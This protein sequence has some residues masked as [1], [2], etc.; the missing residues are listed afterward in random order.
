MSLHLAALFAMSALLTSVLVPLVI[1]I[2]RRT[3]FLDLPG[4]RKIHAAAVPYGGGLA[5]AAGFFLSAGA[6]VA[7]TG[8]G[9]KFP[10]LFAMSG[11]GLVI[12]LLGLID[13]K[14]KL[15]PST[16][17]AV[18]AVV[19][20][21]FVL[22]GERL[23]LFWEG[24]LAGDA[25]GS[26][27]TVLWIVGITNA[28]NLLDHMDGMA[29]GIALLASVAFGIVAVATRQWF[30]AA[31]LAALGGA[32]AGFLRHNWPPARVFLGDA[33]SLFIG[34]ILSTLTVVF[35]F[36]E[37]E[38]GAHPFAYAIPLAVLAVPIYD[39]LHVLLIRARRRRPLFEGDRNHLAHRLLAL[40]MSPRMALFLVYSMTALTGMSAV[41]LL[42][43]NLLA[44]GI[45]LSQLAVTF[46]IISLLDHAGR[47][48]A[49][50]SSNGPGSPS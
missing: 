7:V 48:H 47:R 20:A 4:P 12:L 35:T 38:E 27:V 42:N 39:T 30:V 21:G 36:Y 5:V 14:R 9:S 37:R 41:L 32:C 17:L 50:Q 22:G 3:A 26:L 15:A 13:D 43:A 25:I 40:G 46:V 28:F 6:G 33:G 11:G 18:E 29:S 45:I 24:S 23:S 2:A 34:Y 49:G 31:A 44:A 8:A 19:A 1:R 16:K 10:Q